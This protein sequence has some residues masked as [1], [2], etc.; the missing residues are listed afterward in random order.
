VW[1]LSGQD[2]ATT[3]T[4]VGEAS[5]LEGAPFSRYRTICIGG[6]SAS[7]VIDHPK[8]QPRGVNK[9][10]RNKNPVRG[11]RSGLVTNR[12]ASLIGTT[13]KTRLLCNIGIPLRPRDSPSNLPG[14]LF[15]MKNVRDNPRS[16]LRQRLSR[17]QSLN[18]GTNV[19]DEGKD[20]SRFQTWRFPTEFK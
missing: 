4:Q 14:D 20:T 7:S 11:I 18:G 2:S 1:P 12:I 19:V 5:C 10:D 9:R 15:R 16:I 6:T 13:L 17:G 3:G 8:T